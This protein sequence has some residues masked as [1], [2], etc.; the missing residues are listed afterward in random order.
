MLGWLIFIYMDLFLR[1]LFFF[2]DDDELEV[3]NDCVYGVRDCFFSVIIYYICL[4][5][6]LVKVIIE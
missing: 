6:I 5:R 2:V 1:F 4:L 3:D